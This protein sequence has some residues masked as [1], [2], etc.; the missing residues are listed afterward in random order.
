M[1]VLVIEDEP[2]LLRQLLAVLAQSGIDSEGTGE[3]REGLYL[4]EEYPYDAAVVDLGLPGLPGLEIIRR[5][6]AKG[7][8][9]PIL[10]L[11]AR[12]RWQDKVE[13]LEAGADDYLVKP[14]QP[15]EL[16]ARLRALVRRAAGAAGRELQ[17]GPLR[18]D[19][20]SQ[21]A[22]MGDQPVDLTA[23]EYRL[24]EQL[25]AAQGGVLSKQA[26]AERLYPHDEDRESNVVEVLVGR[27]RRKL[28]PEGKLCPIET[29]RGRGYRLALGDA[30]P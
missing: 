28:D 13:G 30:P 11:T 18:L 23:F 21:R 20:V 5:L 22:W 16:V 1:R 2:H 6:R 19:L 3:G 26:L 24:L 8:L 4:A 29:L 12:D 27:L 25:A 15:E 14:F 17:I 7:S 10:I 9:L